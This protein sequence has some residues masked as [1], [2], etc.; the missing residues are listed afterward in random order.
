METLEVWTRPLLRSWQSW[1]ACFQK[2]QTT[3]WSAFFLVMDGDLTECHGIGGS[4]NGSRRLVR[5]FFTYSVETQIVFGSQNLLLEVE[6]SYA[7]ILRSIRVKTF[8][9]MMW[10]RTCWR[11]ATV[12][13]WTRSLVACLVAQWVDFVFDPLAHHHYVHVL[14]RNVLDYIIW[15]PCCWSGWRMIRFCG[16]GSTSCIAEP[17]RQQHRRR[18]S[19]WLSSQRTRRT[20][21]RQQRLQSRD[22][23]VTGHFQSGL[24]WRPRKTLWRWVLTKG[25]QGIHGGSLQLWEPTSRSWR[26]WKLSEARELQRTM[27]MMPVWQLRSGSKSQRHGHRGV[28]DWRRQ[29]LWHYVVNLILDFAACP[30][31]SGR[32]IFGMITGHTAGIALHVLEPVGKADLIEKL[33]WRTVTLSVWIWQVHSVKER[34]NKELENTSLQDASRFLWRKGSAWVSTPTPRKRTSWW[35]KMD[36]LMQWR[37]RRME[38]R[39]WRKMDEMK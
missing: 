30:L 23:R 19:T 36:P 15:I 21:C 17:R 12:E 5:W 8:W 39:S 38:W 9:V 11:C 25:Q 24:G 6:K 10:C 35:R 22:I 34:I 20:T 1:R 3:Y 37:L 33:W 13:W 28:M 31:N 7:W 29:W 27:T 2:Y 26:S 32:N 14:E 4:E 16:S 18:F